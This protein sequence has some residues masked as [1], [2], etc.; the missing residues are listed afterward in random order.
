MFHFW[1]I[2]RSA[3]EVRILRPHRAGLAAGTIQFGLS[4]FQSLQYGC[5][6]AI[7]H[8]EKDQRSAAG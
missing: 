5:W 4:L 8:I 2:F 1:L 7:N 3:K 6:V